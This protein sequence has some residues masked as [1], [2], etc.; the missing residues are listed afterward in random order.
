MLTQGRITIHTRPEYTI[1]ESRLI[2]LLQ[3]H[4]SQLNE[5]DADRLRRYNESQSTKVD[6][7]TYR[8]ALKAE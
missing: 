3:H 1:Y 4:L 2:G 8:T 5:P 6:D 7:A